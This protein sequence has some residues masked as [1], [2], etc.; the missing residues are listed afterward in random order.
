MLM[1]AQGLLDEAQ[2]KRTIG[3]EEDA[4]SLTVWV[5]WRLNGELVRRDAWCIVKD[6]GEAAE[7]VAAAMS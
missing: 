1:T 2:L 4:Q 7:A 3:F 6:V 5:E